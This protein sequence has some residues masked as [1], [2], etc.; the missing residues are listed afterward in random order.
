MLFCNIL[1]KLNGVVESDVGVVAE[2]VIDTTAVGSPST[3]VN[4]NSKRSNF[5]KMLHNSILV[6]WFQNGVSSKSNTWW[7]S[8]VIILAASGVS[9]SSSVWPFILGDVSKKL[10]VSESQL[11][12]G[13]HAASGS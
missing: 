4:C 11:R 1:L 7:H 5:S 6:V 9:V 2:S 10:D 8:I 13:S 3:G 12:D